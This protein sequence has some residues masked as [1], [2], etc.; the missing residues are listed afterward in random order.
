MLPELRKFKKRRRRLS[1]TLARTSRS[2]FTLRFFLRAANAR[3]LEDL[4]RTKPL[5]LNTSIERKRFEEYLGEF[6]QDLFELTN[7]LDKR[8]LGEDIAPN[9]SDSESF[10]DFDEKLRQT[11]LRHA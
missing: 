1:K 10:D 11:I 2:E 6:R 8:R 9:S 5:T 4:F 7:R 3:E